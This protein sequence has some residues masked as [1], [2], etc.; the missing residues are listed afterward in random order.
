MTRVIQTYDVI[1]AC[2]KYVEN[3]VI[4][5][6]LKFFKNSEG[7]SLEKFETLGDSYF[8]NISRKTDTR[9]AVSV[10]VE[11]LDNTP[12]EKGTQPKTVLRKMRIYTRFTCREICSCRYC[13][14][15]SANFQC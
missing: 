11:T 1:E 5:G 9:G 2:L 7:N 6:M 12:N 13:R 3:E 4:P 14:L 10:K 15:W 8:Q